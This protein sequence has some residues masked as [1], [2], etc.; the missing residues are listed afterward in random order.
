M[1]GS[2]LQLGDMV[3]GEVKFR[4]LACGTKL[5]DFPEHGGNENPEGMKMY[6]LRERRV[7]DEGTVVYFSS[8]DRS[9]KDEVSEHF[10]R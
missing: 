5:S 1:A 8:F 3:W 9:M 2:V 6:K 10:L 7:D 4:N